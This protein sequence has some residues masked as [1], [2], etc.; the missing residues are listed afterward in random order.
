VQRSPLLKTGPMY[1]EKAS[2]ASTSKSYLDVARRNEQKPN[3]DHQVKQGRFT[4]RINKHYQVNQGQSTLRMNKSY[5]Q[6]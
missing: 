3:G 5:N 2:Q 1:S 4:S 6:P